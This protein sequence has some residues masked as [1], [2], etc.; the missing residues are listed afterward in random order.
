MNLIIK[1]EGWLEIRLEISVSLYYLTTVGQIHGLTISSVWLLWIAFL[2]D[3]SWF[4]TFS[5]WNNFCCPSSPVDIEKCS[6]IYCISLFLSDTNTFIYIYINFPVC[7]EMLLS[8]A[9]S[10]HIEYPHKMHLQLKTFAQSNYFVMMGLSCVI[11]WLKAM[12]PSKF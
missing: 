5:R 4:L 12:L 1:L 2:E 10:D 6:N 8:A 9:V 11:R 3:H 7:E